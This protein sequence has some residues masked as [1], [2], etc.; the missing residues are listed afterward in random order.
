MNYKHSQTWY[1]IIWV[2]LLILLYFIWIYLFT[3]EYI[4]F[5]I[6]LAISLPILLLFYNL[7][8]EI[9]NTHININFWIWI[10]K[11]SFLLSDIN[12]IERVKNKWY[13]W[14]WI[15]MLFWPNIVI[16]N[17]SWFDAVELHMSGDRVIRIWSDE[18]EVLMGVLDKRIDL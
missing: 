14:W 4:A 3:W 10:I 11:R 17:V 6:W 7:T 13:Y 5:Y 16:Y 12:K 18:V 9:D 2:L 15:R 8:V 1:V